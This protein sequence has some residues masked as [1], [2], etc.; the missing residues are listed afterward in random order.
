MAD[1]HP[2]ADPAATDRGATDRAANWARNISRLDVSSIPEGATAR[3][4]TGRRMAGPIQGFGRM[5][6]KTY[7][8]RLPLTDVGARDLIA[9][10]KAHF[11][12]FWPPNNT[13]H[14]PLTGIAPGEVA[15]LDVAIPGRMRLSTGVLVLYADD[16]SFTFMTPQGHL[17]AGWIT[18]SATTTGEHVVAQVQELMRASDP[19]CELG[20]SL[21]GHRQ[22]DTFWQQTLTRLATYLGHPDVSVETRVVCVDKRRQ[23][24]RWGNVWYSSLIRSTIYTLGVPA[25]ALL[26]RRGPAG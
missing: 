24:S 21:G 15:L 4:V 12:E 10:W 9:T 18:F 13:F 7:Q 2:V 5:W 20:L 3:N 1:T 16:E 17:L 19:I 22:H 26:N 8:V 6:Q 14:T 23:W 25:R 11:P